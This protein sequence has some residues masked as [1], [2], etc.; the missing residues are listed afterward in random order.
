MWTSIFLQSIVPVVIPCL[1]SECNRF[2][3]KFYFLT[4]LFDIVVVVDDGT[5]SILLSMAINI[6]VFIVERRDNA[7]L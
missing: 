7:I 3:Y 6:L 4:I 5:H 2:L 1:C